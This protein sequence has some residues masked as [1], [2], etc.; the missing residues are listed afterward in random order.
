MIKTINFHIKELDLMKT[1]PKDIYY[2]GNTKLLKNKKIS[3]VGARRPNQYART[4]THELSHKLS[5]QGITIVSGGA[6]GIDTIAHKAAGLGNTIMV[7]GTGLHKRYPS[8][9]KN[10]IKDIEEKGLVLSLF[11][12]NTPSFIYNFPIRNELVVALGD[13]LIV[14]FAEPNSGTLRSVEFALKMN[15]EIYVL[16]HRLNESKGSNNLLKNSLAKAIYDVDEFIEQIS[17][18]KQNKIKDEFLLYCKNN[19]TY[20]EAIKLYASKVYEYELASKIKIVNG[21]I[22]VN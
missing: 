8:I 15:K 16:P 11:Q 1:Y 6:M 13:I 14:S 18:K 4:M 7:A 22:V 2:L 19:P 10:M 21:K 5:K 12:E 20:E 17:S 3:I 9:N